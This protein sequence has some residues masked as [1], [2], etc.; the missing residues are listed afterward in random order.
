MAEISASMV[1]ELRQRTGLG[2]MECKKALTEAA[3][4]LAKAEELLRIKSGAQG[5]EGR[6][7]HRGRRRRR[8]STLRR[9]GKTAAHGRGQLRD[10]F[11]RA[12]T[13][14]SSRSRRSSRSSSP[15]QNPADVAALS[16]L[17][18]A[19]GTV[20]SRA[21]RRWCRR[22]ARTSRSAASCA[23]TPT[24]KLCPVPCTAAAASACSVDD[25][26]RRRR[27]LARMSRCTSP[28][29]R[30]PGAAPDLRSR[31]EVPADLIEK[32]RAIF[33]AQAAEAG[34]PPD[35]VA[36]MVEGR[37]NKFLGGSHAARPAVRQGRRQAD[38]REDT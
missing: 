1:M 25:D 13:T 14:I 29:P 6:R 18:L 36:K 9:D 10:R 23:L 24:A 34:K 35:I 16:A 4:D 38:G 22:S 32:E 5:V 19:G 11:R 21:R 20:E 28:R 17:P 27:R 3:G 26:R 2:M 15:T 8:H 37:I 30:K 7:P 12:R 31:A 33:T